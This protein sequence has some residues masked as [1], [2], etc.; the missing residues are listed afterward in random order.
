[1]YQVG[2]P[3]CLRV[4]AQVQERYMRNTAVRNES[5]RAETQNLVD[6]IKQ[7]R[8]A[9]EEASLTSTPRHDASPS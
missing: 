8:A 9:A 6:E 7:S 1:M 5:M 2:M 3:P 4:A